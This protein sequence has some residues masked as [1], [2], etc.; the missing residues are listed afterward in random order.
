MLKQ[1]QHAV[2]KT[3]G[4][5]RYGMAVL[6]ALAAVAISIVWNREF[7]STRYIFSFIAVVLSSAFGG[8]GPGLVSTVLCLAGIHS[9]SGPLGSLI[10][11]PEELLPAAV[12]ALASLFISEL[13]ER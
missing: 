13:A 9:F 1:L 11:N 2:D 12:F 3:P 8:F 5:K 4:W 7:H 6:L 10:F